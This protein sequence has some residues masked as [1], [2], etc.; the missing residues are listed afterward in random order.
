ML[1]V[2]SPVPRTAVDC[3]HAAL[4][5]L[6]DASST[7]W[8]GEYQSGSDYLPQNAQDI[9]PGDALPVSAPT[10]EATFA[11][12]VREVEVQV[13]DLDQDHSVYKIGFAEESAQPLGFEFQSSRIA[14]LS[15][16]VP[17]SIDQ[18]GAN[19]IGDLTSATITGLSSTSVTVDAGV[20]PPPGGGIEI[21]RSDFG[22]GPDNDRNLVGRF[23]SQTATLP[24]LSRV[25]DYYLRQFDASTPPRYSRFTAALHLDY[26]L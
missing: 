16:L 13:K 11:S 26:P 5:L 22:W 19:Y 2:K 7:A 25:Q 20:V 15:N 17:I 4:A 9:Y 8:A 18:V 14:D 23:T 6:D 10:R 24:R 3:E 21:R 1:D 12:V